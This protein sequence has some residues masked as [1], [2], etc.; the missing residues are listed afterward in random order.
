MDATY[1]AI[2]APATPRRRP[3]RWN[4]A[5]AALCLGLVALR[6]ATT[7][8]DAALFAIA[9]PERVCVVQVAAGDEYV[10]VS[11]LTL[12]G[13]TA[14]A[15]AH[16]YSVLN[17]VFD[18]TDELP[19]CCEDRDSFACTL[20]NVQI[21]YCATYDALTTGGAG[22]NGGSNGR[23]DYVMVTDADAVFFHEPFGAFPGHAELVVA[24]DSTVVPLNWRE[25][26]GMV[27][28]G[29]FYAKSSVRF[30]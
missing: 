5:G 27:M 28:A 13:K 20:T 17:Y 23:C 24:C 18:S 9:S 11:D 2:A 15:E 4:A 3:L 29:F 12:P 19:Q 14:W 16:G 22:A 6:A 10:A 8:P 7:R 26:P 1:G 21:K 30:H 25:A